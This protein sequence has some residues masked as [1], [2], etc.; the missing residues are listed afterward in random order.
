MKMLLK[1]FLAAAAVMLPDAPRHD[2]AVLHMQAVLSSHACAP[3]AAERTLTQPR[4]HA[5]RAVFADAREPPQITTR[6]AI[7]SYARVRVIAICRFHAYATV[8]YC[9]TP[10]A[11]TTPPRRESASVYA[12]CGREA[13]ICAARGWRSAAPGAALDISA[14]IFLS[15]FAIFRYRLFEFRDCSPAF[16][17]R[18]CVPFFG[19]S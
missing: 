14:A 4:C 15:R 7:A 11:F 6:A 1:R 9:F 3:A 5:H 16:S 13:K 12:R 10:F 18:R 17:L 19:H 8:F 2:D